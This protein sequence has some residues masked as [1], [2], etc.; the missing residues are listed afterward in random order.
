MLADPQVYSDPSLAVETAE[1]LT[2]AERQLEP[3]MSEWESLHEE[4]ES[5][6]TKI[7]EIEDS[8]RE[9]EGA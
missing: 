1:L 6:A 2:E 3:L 8:L 9:Q 5:V 7:L 4:R